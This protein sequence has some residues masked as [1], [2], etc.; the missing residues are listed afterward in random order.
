LSHV[1][2]NASIVQLFYI[3]YDM[4]YEHYGLPGSVPIIL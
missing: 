2:Q 3:Y 4:Q 1:H